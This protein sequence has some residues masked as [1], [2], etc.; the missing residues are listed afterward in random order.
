MDNNLI[1]KFVL[2]AEPKEELLLP[3]FFSEENVFYKILKDPPGYLRYTGWNLLTL[4]KPRIREG[5]YWEVTNGERKKIRLFKDGSLVAVAYADNSFL[6]WGQDDKAF[7]N[8]PRINTV[9]LIE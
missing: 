5:K 3:D 8:S 4:D 1:P 7:H 2:A 9:A 6:G